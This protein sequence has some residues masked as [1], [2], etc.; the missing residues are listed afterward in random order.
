MLYRAPTLVY[1]LPM[2]NVAVLVSGTGSLLEAMVEAK[3]PIKLVA[4]D[5]QCRG[6]E[7]AKSAGIAAE[8][9]KRESFKK[10]FDRESYTRRMVE[11]LKKHDIDLVVMAGF[12]TVFAQ[13]IFDAYPNRVLN[14]HPSLG[15]KHKGAHAVR[16]ALLAGDKVAGTTIHVANLEVDV[17]R[18]LA[19]AEVPVLPDDTEETLHERIKVEERKLYPQAIRDFLGEQ[20]PG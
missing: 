8:L 16:D 1:N 3:L 18:I 2:S 17:G 4:A 11:V 7:I 10:D 9:V 5:R 14:S 12:M 13:P 15:L 6:L 20:T 19:Q